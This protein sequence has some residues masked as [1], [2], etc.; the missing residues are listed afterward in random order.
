[1]TTPESDR[2]ST[3][4][5]FAA[6]LDAFAAFAGIPGATEGALG[7]NFEAGDH[8]VRVMPHP[9]HPDW[10]LA[11]VDV[12]ATEASPPANAYE[13]LHRINHAARLQ[14]A[15]TA[16]FDDDGRVVMHTAWPTTALTAANL[17]GLLVEG[18]ERAEALA[19]LWRDVSQGASYHTHAMT[20]AVSGSPGYSAFI[21]G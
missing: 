1:M 16:S 8:A 6:L 5:A 19:A 3:P 9:S 11:E 2:L 15:W 10:L 4:P 12:V 14:H 17:E 21:R 7:L 13:A 20:E 18:L